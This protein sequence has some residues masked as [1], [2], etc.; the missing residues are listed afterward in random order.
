MGAK[1]GTKNTTLTAAV[2]QAKKYQYLWDSAKNNWTTSPNV[3]NVFVMGSGGITS[4]ITLQH[5]ERMTGAMTTPAAVPGMG[6]KTKKSIG[7]E[8]GIGFTLGQAMPHDDIMWLKSCIGDRALGWDLKPPGAPGY[9]YTDSRNQ[10][11]TYA[12]YHQSPEK[13]LKG[14]TPKPIGWAAGIQ[15]DGDIHRANTVLG[16]LSTFYP[17]AQCYEVAGFFWWQGDRDSRDMGLASHYE[18]N[19]VQL[20]KKLRVQ[21]S[22]PNAKFV[23]ASLGQTVQGATDGGGLILD[24]MEAVADPKKYPEFAGNVATVYTHPLLDTPGSSGGHYGDDALTYMNVGEAMGKAMV[25]LLAN[26]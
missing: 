17:G 10:T 13:W 11:W 20:I 23:T 18:E 16:N 2:T 14:T 22:S 6:S 9:D 1:E 7:P 24:A 26:N 25:K 5:N 12:G 19:L 3:Q 8:L 21:Y 15:Y 4:G